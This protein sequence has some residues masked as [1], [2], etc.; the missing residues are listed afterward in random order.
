MVFCILIL[1][2]ATLLNLLMSSSSFLVASLG[3][4]M[5]SIMSSADSDKFTSSFPVWIPFISFPSLIVVTRI[6]KTMLNKNGESGHLCL[7]PDLRGNK[8]QFN[9]LQQLADFT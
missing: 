3:F 9:Q 7:D 6:S 5:Y 2:S 1:Y 4:S 8:D